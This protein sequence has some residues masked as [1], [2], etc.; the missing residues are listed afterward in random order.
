MLD[1]NKI[2]SN[3]QSEDKELIKNAISEIKSEGD[4]NIVPL[5]FEVLKD[6]ELHHS[7]E[8]AIATLLAEIKDPA[9]IPMLQNGINSL[10][11]NPEAQAKLIRVCWEST[12]DFSALLPMLCKLATEGD[13]IVA[14]EATTAIE[15]QLRYANH[16]LLHELQDT[17]LN[18]PQQNSPFAE[19]IL[20]T[21]E[22]QLSDIHSHHEEHN[23][24]CDCPECMA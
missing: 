1:T 24:D 10:N 16:D 21:I 8:G 11:E 18:S 22:F 13:F 5:L 19:D 3:L 7:A 23:D 2:I 4:I 14:M 9:F 12:M 17:L 6:P 15:E 20:N